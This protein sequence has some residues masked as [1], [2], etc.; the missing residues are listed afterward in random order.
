MVV[1]G[2]AISDLPADDTPRANP[3]KLY[4]ETLRPQY[5]FTA[6]YWDEYQLHPPNHHEGWL[7]DLNGLVYNDGEY[8]LFAQRWWS[9]WL[10]AISTDLIHWKELRPAF[11]KGGKFGG[12]QSG[13]GVVDHNNCSGLGNGKEP[14]MIAFWSSTDNQSQCISYSQDKGRTWT[15]YDKNPVLV[16]KFR[17]PKVFWYEPD[18]K[19]IMILYGPS[20]E[21]RCLSTYGFNGEEND[22]HY[23]HIFTAGEWTCS[24]IRLFSDGRVIATDQ[25]G[26]SEGRIDANKQNI[27]A[28][29]LCVGAKADGSEFLE[30]D[31][32]EILVYNRPLS[33]E[34]AKN[35]LASL[36]F[37][38]GLSESNA[39]TSVPMDGLV[40]RLD[41]MDAPADTEGAVS[42]WKDL[43]GNGNDVTQSTADCMPKRFVKNPGLG[44][45]PVVRFE[46]RQFLQGPAVL[47]EGDDTFTLVALWRRGPANGSQ[48]VCEQ[49]A[50]TR[51]PGRRASLL[52]V[53]KEETDNAYLLFTSKNLLDW[54]KLD[55]SIPDSFECPDMFALWVDGDKE[56]MKWVIIDGNGDYVFG[57]FNGRQFT[58]ETRKQKGDYGRNFYATMTF[59]NMPKSDPRRIQLA[60]MRGWD[61]YPKD[62]PF[63]QQVSFPCELTLRRLPRGIVMCRYPIREITSIYDQEF[64]LQNRILK[65]GKNPLSGLEGD[66][67]DINLEIDISQSTCSEIVL[68]LRGNTVKFDVSRKVLHSVGSEVHL[69]PIA[70]LLE[71][72]ILMDRLSIESFGNHG[73]VSITN[74]AYQKADRPHLELSAISGDAKIVSLTAH[75]LKSIWE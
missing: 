17:D 59:E 31:I 62:M 10:H 43:S 52:T 13:G 16:H 37:K 67:F 3:E 20:D 44:G 47:A 54:K 72:R 69:E 9:A 75:K 25:H 55:V 70:G 6:R 22:A 36:Q 11:G 27:S 56:Q 45:H 64:S 29:I 12:T 1:A 41:A 71:I 14:P 57:N 38:W 63:N 19:W 73:E 32:A 74:I 8:H 68:N 40:L 33:D 66:L 46:G 60:W 24:A 2:F 4:H 50:M 58:T 26:S 42:F 48:V 5:H 28:E 53:C 35:T 30:G 7:N 23:L 51:Q 21:V 61:D 49:N 15:K 65:A 39:R 34:E 18:K